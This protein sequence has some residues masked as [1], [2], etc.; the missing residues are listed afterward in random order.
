[1]DHKTNIHELKEKVKDFCEA[2]DWSK[3]HNAKELTIGIVTE[4][5]ELLQIFRF[6]S[7]E[8][9]NKLFEDPIRKKEISEELVDTLY[10]I[11]RLSQMYDIDLTTE[12]DKKIKKN[13][14]KY[15][16]EKVKGINKKY[17]EYEK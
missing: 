15:P 7:E 17:S 1:M 14:D 8:E 2:R 10:F 4:A 6:K 16:V 11:L 13:N 9:V 3:F 5:S 12:L